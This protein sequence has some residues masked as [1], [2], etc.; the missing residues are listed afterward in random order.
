MLKNNDLMVAK[1]LEEKE[2]FIL[3]A[4]FKPIWKDGEPTNEQ[5]IEVHCV[6]LLDDLGF[7]YYRFK[8]AYSQSNVD[9][10][11]KMK[12]KGLVKLTDIPGYDVMKLFNYRDSYFGQNMTD[13]GD[14]KL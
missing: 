2:I 14:V 10:F 12:T 1:M 7:Q 5:A 3:G 13:L 9:F 11:M 8:Y 4:I 6:V